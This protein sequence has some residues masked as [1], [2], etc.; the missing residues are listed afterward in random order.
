MAR[1]YLILI[2]G[3][4]LIL[5]IFTGCKSKEQLPE[6]EPLT[7]KDVPEYKALLNPEVINQYIKAEIE[8]APEDQRKLL[9]KVN[10][11]YGY[12]DWRVAG[13]EAK[14]DNG[15]IGVRSV[16]K[17]TGKDDSLWGHMSKVE[18]VEAKLIKG[19][20]RDN[21]LGIHATGNVEGSLDALLKWAFDT[22]TIDYSIK[23]SGGGMLGT[24]GWNS[25]KI[26]MIS[27]RDAIKKELYPYAGD[28]SALVVYYNDDFI[29]MDDIQDAETI[30]DAFPVR[31]IAALSL[32]KKGLAKSLGSII[33]S[34][35]SAATSA[36][37][38]GFGSTAD[39]LPPVGKKKADGSDIYYYDIAG[40]FQIAW[41]EYEGVLFI[42][43]MDT[44][45]EI[46][47]Y[48][49]P[50]NP[51]EGV[52]PVYNSYS[53]GDIDNLVEKFLIPFEDDINEAWTK[54]RRKVDEEGVIELVDE[55][56]DALH[57]GAKFGKIESWYHN[58]DAGKVTTLK[59]TT[60]FGPYLLKF[61]ENKT[62]LNDM[63]IEY[64]EEMQKAFEKDLKSSM[65][66]GPSGFY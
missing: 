29:G 46:S 49:N 35:I 18:P 57:E 26:A 7:G 11:G 27:A 48:Y 6:E 60:T 1:K 66:G 20:T 34:T 9:E 13:L 61:Y 36:I 31:V 24:V 2:I 15:I 42:S 25:M 16:T 54:G 45:E 50:A 8:A 63:L 51:A 17:F 37:M 21:L 47:K 30:T 12:F 33:E 43:D 14:E 5:F 56:L 39:L 58:S 62:A 4:A 38:G 23:A 10:S 44:I 28:E 32:E 52:P 64:S 19:F 55:L 41:V 22:K 65:M 40:E 53:Y 3:L 59:V